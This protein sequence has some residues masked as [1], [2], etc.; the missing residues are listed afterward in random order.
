ME[1]K[2]QASNNPATVMQKRQIAGTTTTIASYL[3]A[4]IHDLFIY[5]SCMYVCVRARACACPFLCL[6]VIVFVC[7]C[8]CLDTFYDM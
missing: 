5:F 3:A 1:T 2:C 7:L 6:C 8:E 4:R